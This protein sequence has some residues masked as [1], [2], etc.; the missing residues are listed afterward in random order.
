MGLMCNQKSNYIHIH[1]NKIKINNS[2]N[3]IDAPYALQESVSRSKLIF[4]ATGNNSDMSSPEGGRGSHFFFQ[5][6][7]IIYLLHNLKS[8]AL[9]LRSNYKQPGAEAVT[10]INFQFPIVVQCANRV[11]VNKQIGKG[12]HAGGA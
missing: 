10:K 6:L 8:N 7:K 11:E 4:G 1:T 5:A 2:N 9:N 12:R 3:S